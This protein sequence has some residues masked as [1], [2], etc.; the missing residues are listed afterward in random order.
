MSEFVSHASG[1]GCIRPQGN[2]LPPYLLRRSRRWRSRPSRAQVLAYLGQ[3]SGAPAQAGGVPAR[4]LSTSGYLAATLGRSTNV[5]QSPGQ[6]Q[7]FVPAFGVSFDLAQQNVR[8][9]DNYASLAG[10]VD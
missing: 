1:R 4:G 9:P 3:A 10:G 5:N 2:G 8:K 6:A 7:I